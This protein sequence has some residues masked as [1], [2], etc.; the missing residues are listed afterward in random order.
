MTACSPQS[1]RQLT[2]EYKLGEEYFSLVNK[3]L[4]IHSP[5]HQIHS[6]SDCVRISLPKLR[7]HL[8]LVSESIHTMTSL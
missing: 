2:L 1:S 6:S 7:A 3:N 8:Y 5:T 4:E